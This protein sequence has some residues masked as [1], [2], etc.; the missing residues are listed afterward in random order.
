MTQMES[1]QQGGIIPAMNNHHSP[2]EDSVRS[3]S[4]KPVAPVALFALI[5]TLGTVYVITGIFLIGGF[6]L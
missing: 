5:A 4:D 1:I 6:F 2:S 3:N